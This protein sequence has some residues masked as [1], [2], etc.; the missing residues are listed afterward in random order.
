[1]SIIF[2][3]GIRDNEFTKVIDF[4]DN[5]LVS[6]LI[7]HQSVTFYLLYPIIIKISSEMLKININVY[8]V[9]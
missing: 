4:D 5:L 9:F 8:L 3:D 6:S 2:S 1:M 7:I